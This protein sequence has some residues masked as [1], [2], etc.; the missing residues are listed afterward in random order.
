MDVVGPPIGDIGSYLCMQP[1]THKPDRS[2]T[3]KA[4][5]RGLFM[6]LSQD[7]MAREEGLIPP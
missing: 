3:A 6:L 2:T 5:A 4:V 7:G 1:A